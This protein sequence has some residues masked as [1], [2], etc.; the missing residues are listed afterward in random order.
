MLSL[1]STEFT[2]RSLWFVINC[3]W[4]DIESDDLLEPEDV[5][6]ILN[7]TMR[8]EKNMLQTALQMQLEQSASEILLK[9]MKVFN[10]LLI[11][12]Y[13][14]IKSDRKEKEA[15]AEKQEDEALNAQNGFCVLVLNCIVFIFLCWLMMDFKPF[16][17]RS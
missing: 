3:I 14:A 8:N 17:T 11:H 9:D 1:S 13:Q 12:R 4:S 15:E 2:H 6:K 10:E 7:K 16:E 5:E